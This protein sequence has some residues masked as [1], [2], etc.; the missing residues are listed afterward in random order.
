MPFIIDKIPAEIVKQVG[1]DSLIE[2]KDGEKFPEES[3]EVSILSTSCVLISDSESVNS[4][5]VWIEIFL[6]LSK[7]TFAWE[8]S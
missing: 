8:N 2:G 7:A 1:N 6:S 5:S 3:K 4:S